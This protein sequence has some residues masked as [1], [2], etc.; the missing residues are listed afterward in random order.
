MNQD[1]V[2][3]YTSTKQDPSNSDYQLE[4]STAGELYLLG[5]NTSITNQEVAVLS[6]TT[7]NFIGQFSRILTNI[8]NL[9]ARI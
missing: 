6:H 1:C 9:K 3:I 5:D 4:H 7:A 2:I 8:L